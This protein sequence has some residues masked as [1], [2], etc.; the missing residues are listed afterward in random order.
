MKCLLFFVCLFVVLVCWFVCL[1]FRHRV[2]LYSPGS[3]GTHS[4]DQ[5]CLE[6]RNL[7]ASMKC[8]FMFSCVMHEVPQK[9]SVPWHLYLHHH[10]F[11]FN[12]KL[13]F[14]FIRYFLHLHF[15][16]YPERPLYP[17]HALLPN[18]P[19]PASWPWHLVR[20]C[21]CLANTEVDAHSHLLD[22]TQGSQW[23]S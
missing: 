17:S 14:I 16:C 22:G 18:P 13:A 1:F 19:T 8:L 3:P 20:L 6:L 4:V 5:A 9:L 21:Q 15:K 7:P 12:E 10:F 23:R 2:S 11:F